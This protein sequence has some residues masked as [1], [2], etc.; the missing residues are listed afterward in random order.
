MSRWF[1]GQSISRI[2]GKHIKQD[3]VIIFPM[4]HPAAALHQQNLRGALEDDIK[5]LPLLLA[6]SLREAAPP[7]PKVDPDVKQLSLF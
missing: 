1:P 5:K 3:G 7:P 2:H 4:Y 6:E